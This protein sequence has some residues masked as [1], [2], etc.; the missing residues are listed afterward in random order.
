[1]GGK[2]AQL[3]ASWN[4]PGLEASPFVAPSP[5]FQWPFAKRI[6]NK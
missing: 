6:E 1:M 3:L 5:R 4:P 2:I